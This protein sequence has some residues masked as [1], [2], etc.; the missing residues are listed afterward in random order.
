MNFETTESFLTPE[1]DS[2]SGDIKLTFDPKTAADGDYT[3]SFTVQS[4][5]EDGNET[6]EK[7]TVSVEVT[8]PKV[9]DDDTATTDD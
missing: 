3:I 6:S 5:D 8:S 2:A 7:F 9:E 4:T 1:F